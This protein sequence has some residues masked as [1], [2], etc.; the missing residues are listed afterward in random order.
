MVMLAEVAEISLALRDLPAD[1]L[2]QVRDL[3]FALRRDC[4]NTRPIDCSDE[5]TREDEL[6]FCRASMIYFD[7]E[8]PDE[9]WGEDYTNSGG[10]ECLP[11]GT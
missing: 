2:V 4:A 8:H 1:K 3:V 7:A 11:Q 9:D 6:D 5:W 10:S